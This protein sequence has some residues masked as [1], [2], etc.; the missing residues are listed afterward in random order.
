[1]CSN[2]FTLPLKTQKNCC[3][4]CRQTGRQSRKTTQL[5]PP[6]LPTDTHDNQSKRPREVACRQRRPGSVSP[7]GWCREREGEELVPEGVVLRDRLRARQL[8]QVLVFRE[9]TDLAAVRPHLLCGRQLVLTRACPQE[10][11]LK[12]MERLFKLFKYT[13]HRL[14]H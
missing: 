14:S 7:A 8:F 4:K 10:N 1:M 2:D 12:K 6:R 9:I 5:L 3:C 11:L 13:A